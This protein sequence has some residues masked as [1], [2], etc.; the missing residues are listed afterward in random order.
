MHWERI[1]LYPRP[2]DQHHLL[3][4]SVKP[5][6]TL[7]AV[8]AGPRR[9]QPP[10]ACRVPALSYFE[11]DLDEMEFDRAERR[12]GT[13]RKRNHMAPRATSPPGETSQAEP[14]GVEE[15]P[16]MN[17]L[18]KKTMWSSLPQDLVEG[19]LSHLPVSQLWDTVMSIR[20]RRWARIL[21]A[22][23]C[24]NVLGHGNHVDSTIGYIK[25][26]SS[27]FRLMNLPPEDDLCPPPPRVLEHTMETWQ[28]LPGYPEPNVRCQLKVRSV[29]EGLILMVIPRDGHRFAPLNWSNRIRRMVIWNPVS[30]SYRWLPLSAFGYHDPNVIYCL[31]A[32]V[33]DPGR[34]SYKV[35]EL[36][37]SVVPAAVVQSVVRAADPTASGPARRRRRG[38]IPAAQDQ[39]QIS[40]YAVY[41]SATARWGPPQ[42]QPQNISQVL[43]NT[44]K[45]TV[46]CEGCVCFVNVETQHSRWPG[47]EL[48]VGLVCY[49]STTNAWSEVL[50]PTRFFDNNLDHHS[51]CVVK[52][53]LYARG[54]VYMIY[55]RSPKGQL[56]TH[57]I[58]SIALVDIKSGV[59]AFK[60][61][62]RVKEAT[63]I[64]TAAHPLVIHPPPKCWRSKPNELVLQ[65]PCAKFC[66]FQWYML[67]AG[68]TV[69]LGVMCCNKW[70]KRF[71]LDAGRWTDFLMKVPCEMQHD[72]KVR[73]SLGPSGSTYYFDTQFHPYIPG[74][75]NV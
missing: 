51:G 49:D 5:A 22:N 11:P 25:S 52:E 45:N 42:P 10:R 31:D 4:E 20:P 47:W 9:S 32:V 74:W 6:H 66:Q 67:P 56:Y 40:G 59:P 63:I 24:T 2:H 37:Q 68:R 1:I 53:L 3:H 69:Y 61:V 73:R 16:D 62:G 17:L 36:V 39:M 44:T 38:F 46:S 48:P 58:I 7:R 35:I 27:S 70:H 34:T 43:L 26:Y 33:V 12:S 29:S 41:D 19:V 13:K 55:M 65:R 30:K 21:Y 72:L 54:K 71:D 75:V 18:K 57:Y 14:I 23:G 50:F 15:L 8:M 28:S 60:R 64:P